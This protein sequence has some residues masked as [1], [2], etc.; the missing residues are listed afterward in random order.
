MFWKS[1]HSSSFK[2]ETSGGQPHRGLA[3]RSAGCASLA[4]LVLVVGA[5]QP[6]AQQ[7]APDGPAATAASPPPQPAPDSPTAERR[8]QLADDSA[9]L[10]AMAIALKAEVDKTNKDT[11]SLHVIRKAGEIEK[12]AH[13]VREKMRFAAG[14]N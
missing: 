4:S 11:L 7:P 9:Q 3:L 12:L 10:L 6:G 14:H 5:A 2:Y 13:N 8:K 1:G